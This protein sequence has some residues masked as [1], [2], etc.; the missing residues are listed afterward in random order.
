ME[1]VLEKYTDTL[2]ELKN[3]RKDAKTKRE[4]NKTYEDCISTVLRQQKKKLVKVKDKVYHLKVKKS[5]PAVNEEF[6][7]KYLNSYFEN[8]KQIPN[9]E[10]QSVQERSERATMYFLQLR[11]ELSEP[12]EVLAEKTSGC[13]DVNEVLNV[14]SVRVE[15]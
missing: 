6:M 12:K 1:T 14:N 3:L 10:R 8:E 2:G 4:E 7:R 11:K 15:S 13:I 5:V 9:Y